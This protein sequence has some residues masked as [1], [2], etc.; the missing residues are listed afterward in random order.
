MSEIPE[1]DI[2]LLE[3]VV[4]AANQRFLELARQCQSEYPFFE[5]TIHL[6]NKM[7]N[8]AGV[9]IGTIG[10]SYADDAISSRAGWIPVNQCMSVAVRRY[11]NTPGAHTPVLQKMIREIKEQLVP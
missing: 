1:S 4:E 11:A 10:T 7:P 8:N 9:S 6:E 2:A 3:G 5:F